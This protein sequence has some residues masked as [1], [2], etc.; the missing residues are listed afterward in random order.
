MHSATRALRFGIVSLSEE[1]MASLRSDVAFMFDSLERSCILLTLQPPDHLRPSSA[2]FRGSQRKNDADILEGLDLHTA[3]TEA[4]DVR[5]KQRSYWPAWV[6][7]SITTCSRKSWA[8]PWPEV[9]DELDSPM[10]DAPN[11]PSQL[12]EIMQP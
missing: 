5:A 7:Q 12:S 8:D 2:L 11:G 1:R 6:T 9:L 4:A 3:R 10:A